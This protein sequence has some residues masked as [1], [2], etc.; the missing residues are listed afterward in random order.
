MNEPTLFPSQF[1]DEFE[2][3][4]QVDEFPQTGSYI[5]VD[6]KNGQRIYGTTQNQNINQQLKNYL[7]WLNENGKQR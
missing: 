1:T 3:R 7:K 6:Q 5:A 4:F 2:G